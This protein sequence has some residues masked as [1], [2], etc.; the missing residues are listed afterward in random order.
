MSFQSKKKKR[1]RKETE[2]LDLGRSRGMQG[3]PGRCR[4]VSDGWETEDS[5]SELPGLSKQHDERNAVQSTH[6]RCSDIWIKAGQTY[7]GL[8]LLL[9][10]WNF[11]RMAHHA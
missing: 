3:R 5:S 2:F 6:S 11:L 4:R 1:E 10:I 8:R 7:T 9:I